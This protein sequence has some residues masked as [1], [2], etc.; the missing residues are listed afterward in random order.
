MSYRTLKV[1]KADGVARVEL[2]RPERLNTINL[3][4]LDEFRAVF[5]NLRNDADVK[6]VV[7][8]GAEVEGRR[9]AFSAGADVVTLG[10]DASPPPSKAIELSRKG[11]EV[12]NMVENFEKPVIARVN[13]FALGG[14]CELAAACDFIVA[15]EDA[16][17]GQP[18]ISLGIIPGWGG[19]Q[20]LPRR[21]GA[22]AALNLILTGDRIP[23]REAEHIGLVNKVAPRE[24]LDVAVAELVKK[25]MSKSQFT[26][27]M[28]K[29]AVRQGL[30]TSLEEGL[31]LEAQTFAVCLASE[32]A[33]E[34]IT[35]FKE[36][37]PPS[38]KG[39]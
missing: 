10:F 29:K 31:Q 1:A 9:P 17:F 21:I 14:G 32:D 6:I 7:L 28:A 8:T 27:G 15:A 20:R 39:K 22:S 34:G 26:L 3:E 5:E 18:E 38:F 30:K 11:Q 2:N 36:K 37:R 24:Q 4:V 16:E 12:F 13:G 19:T 25:L 23:A 33:K 35:A